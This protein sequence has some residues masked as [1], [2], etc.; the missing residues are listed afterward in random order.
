M[1][2]GFVILGSVGGAIGAL[3]AQLLGASL[4]FIVLSYSLTGMLTILGTAVIY[5]IASGGLRHHLAKHN[6]RFE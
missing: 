5:V 4:I 6:Y 3:V 2:I 1:L